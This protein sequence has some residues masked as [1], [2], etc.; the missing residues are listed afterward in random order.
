MIAVREFTSGAECIAH[1]QAV[2]ER[3]LK[4]K[5]R[6]KTSPDVTTAVTFP[7]PIKAAQ[8]PLW[9]QFEFD[10]DAHVIAYRIYLNMMERFAINP[11]DFVFEPPKKPVTEIID[12]V[13][14]RY[15]GYTLEDLRGSRRGRDVVAPRQLAMYEVY[16]QR[17]DL[18]LPWIGRFFGGRDHTTVLNAVRRVKAQRGEFDP[19]YLRKRNA[20]AERYRQKAKALKA[21]AASEPMEA[22]R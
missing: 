7:K 2:R 18:S 1:A 6:Q 4:A 12:E 22:I 9:R 19:Q 10:F 15:P 16:T 14:A 8:I 20:A 5:F 17:K 21:A 13:L 11:S 3:I